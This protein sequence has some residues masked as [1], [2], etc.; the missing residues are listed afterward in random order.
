MVVRY[1]TCGKALLRKNMAT[2]FRPALAVTTASVT[3][4]H[5]AYLLLPLPPPLAPR[6]R[7]LMLELREGL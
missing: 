6:I 5:C 2:A 7:A 4:A 3:S 1:L